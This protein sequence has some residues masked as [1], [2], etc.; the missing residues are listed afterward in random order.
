MGSLAR[1]GWGGTTAAWL[2]ALGLAVLLTLDTGRWYG[3]FGWIDEVGRPVRQP[4]RDPALAWL[5]RHPEVEAIFGSYW[6][7]YRLAFLSGGTIRGVPYPVYPQRDPAWADGLPGAALAFLSRARFGPVPSTSAR[8]KPREPNCCIMPAT[9]GSSTGPGRL[10]VTSADEAKVWTPERR[11]WGWG[12]A[13]ALLVWTAAIVA[14]FWN[15][16]ALRGAFFYFDITEINY[17]YRAFLAE[18]IRAGRFSRWMPGLY[19]GLPLYSESQAGYLHPLKYLLY[20]WMPTWAAFNYDTVLSV[21]LTGLGAFGWLRR[22]VGPAGALTGA[23]I[24]GLSGFTWAHLVHTSM[25]NAL[26]SVPLAFWALECT[27]DGGRLRGVALGALALACQVFAGHLQDTILT[28]LALGLYGLY[29]AAI[30]RGTTRRAFAL[31]TA[32]GIVGLAALLAAVQWIP[33]KELI[34]RSPR[35]GGMTW[36]EQTFG[37]WS[38]ELLPTLLLREAYGTRA[39]DTDW[40]DG[41]YPYHEMNTYMS[42]VGLALAVLGLAAYRDRW[43]GFWVILGGLGGLLM[44]GRFTILSDLLARVPV[45]N[46]GRIPVRYHL[47]VLLAVAALASV[48]VDRLARPGR[49]RLR[50]A[51]VTIAALAVVSV[52]ILWYVYEPAWTEAQRWATAYHKARYR[53]LGRELSLALLRTGL[54]ALI[55]W[56]VAGRA[57]R[58]ASPRIRSRLVFLLPLLVMADLLGAY[59]HDAPTVDPA[60]WTD[61][62]PSVTQLRADPSLI[63][64]F[65]MPTR[66]AGEPGYA[67]TEVDFFDARDPLG[68]SL[69]PVWD[70]RSSG[71]LT[72]IHARRTDWYD[73]MANRAGVRFDLESVSHIL[74]GTLQDVPRFGPAERAGSAFIHSNPDVL[75]RARL[76]GRPVYARDDLDAARTLLRLGTAARERLIVE[77]PARPL[78]PDSTVSGRA[79]IVTD[80]P[81]SVVIQTASDGPA[82]LVL[83]DTFDPGWSATLDG[84]PVPIR[85]AYVAFRAVFVPEGEHTVAFFY[86][87]AGF[88]TGLAVSGVGVC[89]FLFCLAWPRPLATLAPIHG[90][91]D[92]PRRW[93]ALGLALAVVVLVASIV[94]IRPDGGVGVQE[95]WSI[96]LHRFTWGAGLE[97]IQ[98]PPPPLE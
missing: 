56:A 32:V 5:K 78:P 34:D 25:I 65:G 20:P 87:P 7:V 74:T 14:F 58:G 96:A 6:D 86:E 4:L 94:T 41:F 39:R 19:C 30:E 2:L 33:S 44:L 64:V 68:W 77:D 18:E 70:I 50:W 11:P 76:V 59:W 62:P 24:V 45:L 40:M 89:L 57:A 37:S 53:W 47:W 8:P 9:C 10:P 26:V 35:A 83:A 36:G 46:T 90:N 91:L 21:W 61:P 63:R 43:V 72:P 38:P 84:Q 31:G 85:P 3:R 80:K 1:Q 51:V 23:A 81:E 95:R 42:V 54:I 73:E 92:W 69:A 66:S 48:G 75:P 52:P 60:Y 49:V 82:Y 55:G 27:W 67:S 79:E 16:V 13:L 71:G 28:G 93:P 98:P 97:A 17:P 29:R 15:A 88:R 12:D 22:H